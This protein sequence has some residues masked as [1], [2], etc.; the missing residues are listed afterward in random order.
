MSEFVKLAL[1]NPVVRWII[2]IFV[3]LLVMFGLY[4]GGKY[5]QRK[6]TE[7]INT[8]QN[9]MLDIVQK[10]IQ[11]NFN[12]QF[13]TLQGN[14]NTQFASIDQRLKDNKNA[15]EDSRSAL[16]HLDNVWM[17]VDGV[18]STLPVS[19]SKDKAIGATASGSGSHGTYY[20]KL[21]DSSLQFLKGEA[22]RADRCAVRLDAAQ[23]TLVQYK[24]A[25]EEYQKTVIDAL[26][27]ATLK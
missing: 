24:G 13:D 25:F 23:Q 14:I 12:T 5:A 6:V 19:D 8:A 7:T 17:R 10:N 22:Y 1:G 16:G 4:Q 9:Q 20:A 3:I 11:S 15:I 26:N 21:P 18:S 2:G 27:E